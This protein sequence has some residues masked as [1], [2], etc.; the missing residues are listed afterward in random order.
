MGLQFG[1]GSMCGC[2][3]KSSQM[4]WGS[5]E[6]FADQGKEARRQEG[7]EGGRDEWAKKLRERLSALGR[8][9]VSV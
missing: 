2:E 3:R 4:T 5:A 1:K 6:H 8:L 9:K 7:Q